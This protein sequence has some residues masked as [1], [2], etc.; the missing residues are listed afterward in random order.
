MMATQRTQPKHS[1]GPAMWEDC[2][3]FSTGHD[4][5]NLRGCG[6][7]ATA[8]ETIRQKQRR[9]VRNRCSFHC[10]A[11][12]M[13]LALVNAVGCNLAIIIFVPNFMC[14]KCLPLFVFVLSCFDAIGHQVN[15]LLPVP[16]F[17]SFSPFEA[18]LLEKVRRMT[19]EELRRFD[20]DRTGIVDYALKSSVNRGKSVRNG[21]IPNF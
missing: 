17:T 16:T 2:A 5:T 7:A 11:A 19:R 4:Q 20:A 9:D 6:W 21:E 12:A 1:R 14:G 10:K 8:A 13:V 18:A 15:A 3:L